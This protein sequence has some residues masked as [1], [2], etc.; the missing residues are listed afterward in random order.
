MLRARQWF[1]AGEPVTVI[2]RGDGFAVS[3]TGEALG[4]GVDGQTVR[5]RTDSGRIVVGTPV[6]DRRVEV[7]L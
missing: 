3:G 6:G 1:A 2:A 5:V 7:R 4:P